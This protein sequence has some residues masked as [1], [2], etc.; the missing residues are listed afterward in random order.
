MN[1]SMNAWQQS[2]HLYYYY[3]INQKY[4]VTIYTVVQM[5]RVFFLSNIH[6]LIQQGWV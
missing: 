6:T 1:K 5:F 2:K 3:I 4:F